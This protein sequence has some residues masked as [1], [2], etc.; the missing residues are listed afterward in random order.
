M[1]AGPTPARSHQPLLQ[2][3]RTPSAADSPQTRVPHPHPHPLRTIK[4]GRGVPEPTSRIQIDGARVCVWVR[5]RDSTAGT[6]A[7][8]AGQARIGH[9]GLESWL[10]L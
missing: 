3:A 6:K 1:A 10:W 4:C 8:A 7:K 9:M 5:L 2:L